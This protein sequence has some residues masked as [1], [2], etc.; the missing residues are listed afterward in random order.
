MSYIQHNVMIEKIQDN[1]LAISA[2]TQARVGAV[3]KANGYGH[4][5]IE[6]A[7]GLEK[8]GCRLFFVGDVEEGVRVRTC[9]ISGAIFPLLG[10]HNSEDVAKCSKYE[11]TPVVHMKEQIALVRG[12]ARP[13]AIKCDTGMSRLGF[14]LDELEECLALCKEYNIEIGYLLSHLTTSLDNQSV[15]R[16]KEEF[17]AMCSLVRSSYPDVQ[18]SL[19]NSGSLDCDIT[20]QYDIVR[21]GISLYGYDIDIV[22]VQPAM[23][24]YTSILQIRD[25]PQGRTVS[26]NNT[27]VAPYDMRVAS[28]ACGYAD[29]Y[30]RKSTG[31]YVMIEGEQAPIIGTICMQLCIVDISHIEGV[32]LSSKA[33]IIQPSL[34]L[35]A[36]TVGSF[37]G[38]IPFEVLCSLGK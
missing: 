21:C 27:F 10:I 18:V 36:T 4:G 35:C 22:K 24:V 30:H 13:I 11:L 7:Q 25:I 1:F 3:I 15:L 38:T 6:V 37:W 8:V 12:Y 23:E 5:S 33:Y 28:I 26:Y 32:T 2:V 17:D 9:G 14:R 34:G 16:Q 31:A 20:L 19:G 29:G